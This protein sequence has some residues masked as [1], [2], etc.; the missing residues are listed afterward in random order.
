MRP[1]SRPWGGNPNQL[2]VLDE[3]Q[4][5]SRSESKQTEGAQRIRSRFTLL[6]SATPFSTPEAALKL[7]NFLRRQ[8]GQAELHFGI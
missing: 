8:A 1:V 3:A 6:L 5:F 7:L 4:P 2:L